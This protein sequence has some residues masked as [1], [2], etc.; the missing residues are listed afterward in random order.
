[1]DLPFMIEEITTAALRGDTQK[2]FDGILTKPEYK[3]AEEILLIPAI[4]LV[5]ALIRS[6]FLSRLNSNSSPLCLI[7][8]NAVDIQNYKRVINK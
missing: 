3:S 4:S 2:R 8:S 7:I 6:S 5:Y 1:M